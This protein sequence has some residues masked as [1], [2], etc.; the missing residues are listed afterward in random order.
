MFKSQKLL[1]DEMIIND[2]KR[3]CDD[4]NYF[5]FED[6]LTTVMKAFSRDYWIGENC[7]LKSIPIFGVTKSF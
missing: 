3:T 7:V 1:V 2:V 5:I 4:E 6:L